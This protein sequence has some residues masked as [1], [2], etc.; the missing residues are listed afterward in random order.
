MIKLEKCQYDI[1]KEAEK[2]LEFTIRYCLN[3]YCDKTSIDFN[4]VE[5]LYTIMEI[6]PLLEEKEKWEKIGYEICKGMKYALENKTRIGVPGMFSG[7]GK[8]AFAVRTFS[9]RTG[10]LTKFSYSLNILLLETTIQYVELIKQNSLFN[11]TRFYDVISGVSGVLYYLLDFEWRECDRK[12]LYVIINYLLDLK[13]EK[14]YCGEKRLAF[15]VPFEALMTESLKKSFPSGYIDLGVAHGI[16]GVGI[17]LIKAYEKG[18]ERKKIKE[19]CSFLYEFY[20][21]IKK[22]RGNIPVWPQQISWQEYK[23]KTYLINMFSRPSWCYGNLAILKGFYKINQS[24]K[25]ANMEQFKLLFQEILQQPLQNFHFISPCICHGMAS[26]ILIENTLR[27]VLDKNLL[28][29]KLEN[30]ITEIKRMCI[31][32]EPK[33]SEHYLYEQKDFLLGMP[34]I[35]CTLCGLYLERNYTSK[36]FLMD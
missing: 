34:G 9:E 7:L 15:F 29:K 3:I 5:F 35:I 14:E 12:K 6:Y 30:H 31:D 25:V 27:T 24:L 11:S 8:S 16:I 19:F 20:G 17:A 18:Y 36:L 28:I 32:S 21:T 1:S 22:K 4:K 26:L 10:Q 33:I 23:D 13:K 2:D